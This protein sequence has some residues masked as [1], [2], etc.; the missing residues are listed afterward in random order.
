[1]VLAASRPRSHSSLRATAASR[2]RSSRHCEATGLGLKQAKKLVEGDPNSIKEG[3]DKQ[4]A[5][6]IAGAP[7]QAGAGV[8]VK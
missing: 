6:K 3:I 2:F 8:E 5:D 1:M 7:K 4:E